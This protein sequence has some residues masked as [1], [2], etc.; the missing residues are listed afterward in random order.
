MSFQHE[1]QRKACAPM[2]NQTEPKGQRLRVCSACCLLLHL[3]K[4]GVTD[5]ANSVS[6]RVTR[7]RGKI[8]PFICPVWGFKVQKKIHNLFLNARN[9]YFA[10]LQ[11]LPLKYIWFIENDNKFVVSP[12][13]HS[14][15]LYDVAENSTFKEE[16]MFA[17]FYFCPEKTKWRPLTPAS[18]VSVSHSLLQALFL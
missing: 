11:L 1:A 6:E 5:T 7:R 17:H 2:Y 9:H 8:T 18:P 15:L 16:M 4:D 12:Q 3:H 14:I 13:D 10:A